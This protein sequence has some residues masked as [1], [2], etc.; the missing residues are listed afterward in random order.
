MINTCMKL[1]ELITEYEFPKVK[2][3]KPGNTVPDFYDY[4]D[5]MDSFH[6]DDDFRD[7][8][9]KNIKS[10]RVKKL[11]SGAFS[12][13]YQ[14][15]D[16]PHDVM[17]GSKQQVV[18]DGYQIFFTALE[19][20]PEMQSNPYFPRF[21]NISRYASKDHR[22]SSYM[23]KVETLEPL[24]KLTKKELSALLRRILDEDGIKQVMDRMKDLESYSWFTAYP[25]HYVTQ[26]AEIMVNHPKKFSKH[27]I[28]KDFLEAIQFIIQV[29]TDWEYHTDLHE[30]NIMLRRTPY[31]VQLV[32]NDPLG[33]SSNKVDQDAPDIKGHP[34]WE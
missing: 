3:Q 4:D 5:G 22:S 24:Q 25:Y 7:E 1:Y 2:Y 29:A 11:G 8:N 14:D 27:V 17:K 6:T 20:N 19:E 34:D 23:V 26:L 21:R 13:A 15:K 16:N 9:Q 30:G 18:P 31:G 32:F 12:T 33:F 28:D 10:D